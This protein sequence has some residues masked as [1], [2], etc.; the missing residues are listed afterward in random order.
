MHHHREIPAQEFS[1]GGIVV[2]HRIEVVRK[3]SSMAGIGLD[4]GDKRFSSLFLEGRCDVIDVG[5][6]GGGQL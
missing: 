2:F 3:H 5:K 1:V 4:Q 6:G